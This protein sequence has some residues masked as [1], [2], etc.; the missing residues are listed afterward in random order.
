[1]VSELENPIVVD[2]PLRGEWLAVNTPAKKIPSHGTNMLG[3]RYA[4]DFVRTDDRKGIHFSDKGNLSYI[5]SGVPVRR[6]YGWGEIVYS[7]LDGEVVEMYDE[8]PE[9]TRLLP[10]L[11]IL[12]VIKNGITFRGKREDL[13]KLTG[14]YIILKKDNFFAFFAHMVPGSLRV[15]TGDTVQTGQELGRVGHT[16][17]STAPHLHFQLMD[18]QDLLRAE[19]IPCAFQEYE[20]C[21][22]E[23]WHKI[24]TGFPGN[25]KKYEA[26]VQMMKHLKPETS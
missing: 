14:N 17:N 2:F 12:V 25:I 16:G 3:Q 24:L 5:L 15:Q 13:P 23:G 7:P 20:E 19:G 1:M 10:L 4:Y 6:C 26:M 18:R 8:I 11:D 9:R 21:G 22:E